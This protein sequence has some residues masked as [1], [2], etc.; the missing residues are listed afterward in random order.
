MK[1]LHVQEVSLAVRRLVKQPGATLASVA[2]LACGLAAAATTWALLSAVLVHPLPLKSPESLQIVGLQ[3][4]GRDGTPGRASYD[5]IFPFYPAIRDSDAFASVAAIGRYGLMVD[6]GGRP[7]RRDVSFASHNFFSVLGV[8]LALGTGFRAED[9]RRGASPVAVLSN[10]YW[11]ARLNSDPAVIGRTLKVAGTETTIVG[12]APARFRGL[13]LVEAPDFYMPMFTLPVVIDSNSNY[14]MDGSS[15]SSPSAWLRVVGRLKSGD[16]VERAADRIG[17]HFDSLPVETR[18]GATPV[19]VDVNTAALPERSREGMKQFTQLLTMTVGLLLFIGSLTVGM[20]LLIR[21]ESRRDEF[22]MCIAL[23]ATRRRLGGGVVCEGG[24]LALA[25]T[26]ASVPVMI[27][28]MAG[29]S[30]F[31]L[32]GG[33]DLELLELSASLPVLG[34]AALAALGCT[35]VIGLVAAVFGVSGHIGD[36]LRSRAG[37][38]PRVTRRRLRMVLVGTQVSVTLVLLVGT[39]LFARS[40]SA[41]LRLNPGYDAEHLVSSGLNL[42]PYG[43]TPARADDFYAAL[44]QR[45]LANPTIASV[46]FS[47]SPLGMGGGGNLTIDGEPR[48]VPS[49]VPFIHVDDRYFSTIRLPILK[50]RDFGPEDGPASPRVAIVSESLGRWIANGGDP[51]GHA[52]TEGHNAPGKPPAVVRVVGVV[53]DVVTSVRVLEP[54][55]V[56]YSLAQPDSIQVA[57]ATSRTFT[58]RASGEAQSAIDETM[59]TIR[60]LDPQLNPGPFMTLRDRIN[61][62]MG[63]QQFGVTVLGALG[64]IAVLLTVLGTYVLAETM[65]AAR[66]REMGIRAALGATRRQLGDLV[67]RETLQLV[68]AGLV[69]GLGLAWLGAGTIRAFLFQVEPLDATVLVSMSGLIL[70]LALGVSLRPAIRAGQVQLAQLLREE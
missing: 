33:V 12:V 50:G 37:A 35:V 11:R 59:S 47:Q 13:S 64:V 31:E 62:Q 30:A 57:T 38:T 69:A 2:T 70:V 28:L 42:R 60:S 26:A 63:P 3:Y 16:T 48:A 14:F 54:M 53:P 58:I 24:L 23:G 27:W 65:A 68:G 18:R 8:N 45:L 41:A 34:T 61:M 15:R 66:K 22:A 44:R 1:D 4:P 25:G 55:A 67:L 5:L 39:G 56:Y 17:V 43:Y 52:I 19:F 51:L 29:L 21:T 46:T 10:R 9:D 49:Y 36:V 7:E 20:L 6:E 32:P 40:L